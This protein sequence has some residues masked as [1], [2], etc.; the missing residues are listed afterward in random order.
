MGKGER[1]RNGVQM[2]RVENEKGNG[3]I[4]KRG[5]RRCDR[6]GEELGNARGEDEGLRVIGGN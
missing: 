4:G 5:E 3:V 1:V 2:R 6:G